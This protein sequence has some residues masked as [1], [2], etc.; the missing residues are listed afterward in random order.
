MAAVGGKGDRLKIYLTGIRKTGKNILKATLP[1]APTMSKK[2]IKII[3]D[4]H[5]KKENDGREIDFS[6]FVA[7]YVMHGRSATKGHCFTKY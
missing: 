7:G 5:T 4:Y 3:K 6:L 2:V 1:Q